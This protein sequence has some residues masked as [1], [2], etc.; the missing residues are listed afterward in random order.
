MGSEYFSGILEF[1]RLSGVFV[2]TFWQGLFWKNRFCMDF[3]CGEL[4]CRILVAATFSKLF[5]LRRHLLQGDGAL[6]IRKL[7]GSNSHDICR[8]IAK[9]L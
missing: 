4:I 8:T 3:F 9:Y 2:G 1:V 5:I 6:F 7:F